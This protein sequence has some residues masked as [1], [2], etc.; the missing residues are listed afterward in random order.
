TAERPDVLVRRVDHNEIGYLGNDVPVVVQVAAKK[1]DGRTVRVELLHEGKVKGAQT[2]K[3][4]SRNFS[5]PVTF[6][7]NAASR[8]VQHFEARI[9]GSGY[10]DNARDNF[11]RFEVE[12]LDN[13]QKIL[14]LA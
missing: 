4:T 6:T 12:V 14:L 7:L 8:G 5:E 13:K 11:R 9:T 3:I 10:E 2:L 1:A